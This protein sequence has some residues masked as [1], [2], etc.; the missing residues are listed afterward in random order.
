M[1]LLNNTEVL[2]KKDFLA[3]DKN[4]SKTQT[5][6]LPLSVQASISIRTIS[7]TKSISSNIMQTSVPSQYLHEKINT[8]SFMSKA[9]FQGTI[10]TH[11][12]S[13]ILFTSKTE[14]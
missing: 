10:H 7:H 5:Y 3:V 11:K 8:T 14:I 6:D 1:L 9:E 13:S 12:F 2:G 4:H